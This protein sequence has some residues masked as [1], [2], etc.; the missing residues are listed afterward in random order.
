MVQV[1]LKVGKL[2]I[3]SVL[4]EACDSILKNPAL[5]KTTKTKRAEA[6]PQLLQTKNK[7]KT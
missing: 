6:H 4:R 3:E 1:L 7:L 2:E 5:D